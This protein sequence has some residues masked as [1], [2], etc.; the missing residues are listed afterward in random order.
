MMSTVEMKNWMAVMCG[1]IL[2][3]TGDYDRISLQLPAYQY[4]MIYNAASLGKLNPNKTFEI[5]DNYRHTRIMCHPKVNKSGWQSPLGRRLY[6]S[7]VSSKGYV[8]DKD[9]AATWEQCFFNP[10]KTA[11]YNDMKFRFTRY[12]VNAWNFRRLQWTVFNDGKSAE[13]KEP[14]SFFQLTYQKKYSELIK[15]LQSTSNTSYGGT[16]NHRGTSKS[17][18]HRTKVTKK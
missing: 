7:S 2:T 1:K 12:R 17:S 14:C 18:Y 11:E 9:Y 15:T 10:K 16:R 4:G 3:Y 13:L 5:N 8:T 6:Y